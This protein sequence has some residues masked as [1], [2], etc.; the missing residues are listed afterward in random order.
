MM[1]YNGHK[2]VHGIKVQSL[3][4][5]NGQIAHMYGPV[6]G[7]RHGGRTFTMSS[8]LP[9]LQQYARDTQGRL[10][11]YRDPSYQI[12]VNRQAPFPNNPLTA[13]QKAYNRAMSQVRVSVEWLFG[14]IVNWLK[15]LDCWKNVFDLYPSY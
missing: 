10:C 9:K 14:D 7:K 15:F 5:P 2:K 12:N 4:T 8:L 6:D 11:I 1:I 13:D 3:V